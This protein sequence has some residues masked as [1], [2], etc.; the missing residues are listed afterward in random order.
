LEFVLKKIEGVKSATSKAKKKKSFFF[1]GSSIAQTKKNKK[2]LLL[3]KV[4]NPNLL[5]HTHFFNRLLCP[6]WVYPPP[7]LLLLA[8]GVPRQ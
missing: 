5:F 4:S 8:F 3:F 6:C 1:F 7:P 2:S